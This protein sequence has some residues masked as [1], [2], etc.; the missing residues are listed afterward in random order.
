MEVRTREGEFVGRGFYHPR[1]TIA[2]RLLTEDPAEEIDEAFF[3]RSLARAKTLREN[4]LKRPERTDAYRLAHA[5]ADGLS[6]IVIDKF[7]DVLVVEAF[8]AGALAAGEWIASALRDLYPQARI[9]FRASEKTQ[10]REG[11]S[12]EALTRK[13]P[14]PTGVEIRENGLRLRVDFASIHKTGYFLDQRENRLAVGEL[15][16]GREVF[17]LFS[18][19]GGFALNALRGG[20][21][22]VVAVELDELAIELARENARLNGLPGEEQ[23]LEFRHADVFDFLRECVAQGQRADLA[24]AD[25]AK[26]AGAKEELPR[27]LRTYG[28]LNRLAV[29]AVKPGGILVT[30]SCSGLVSEETFRSVVSR[31][32]ALAGSELQVFRVTGAGPDHP[33]SSVFPEGRYLKVIFARVL[34]RKRKGGT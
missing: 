17:D 20:A 24:I 15:A 19:T 3:R 26:L 18:Y 32:A 33:V 13:Y 7:A 28:D 5:E 31:S 34:E 12:F 6:G 8:T 2:I 10:E 9:A 16:A 30:C 1:Q 14:A 27:A 21:K 29:Q 11:V 4:V 25:P 23:A 22:K